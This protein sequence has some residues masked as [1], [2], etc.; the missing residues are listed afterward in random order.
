MTD[1]LPQPTDG[2]DLQRSIVITNFLPY[3]VGAVR[4]KKQG[5]LYIC[6]RR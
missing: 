2:P 5:R 1:D 4:Q 6:L 3:S